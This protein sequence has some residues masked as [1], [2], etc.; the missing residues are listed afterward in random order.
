MIITAT[1]CQFLETAWCNSFLFIQWFSN[2]YV[3]ATRDLALP[4]VE[5]HEQLSAKNVRFISQLE[6]LCWSIRFRSS[7]KSLGSAMPKNEPVIEIV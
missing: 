4:F 2:E 1:K 6:D 5:A 7:S 3:I